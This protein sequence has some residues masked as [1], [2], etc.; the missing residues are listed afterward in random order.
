M[1]PIPIPYVPYESVDVDDDESLLDQEAITE[2]LDD[3]RPRAAS[4]DVHDA[5]KAR[6]LDM[7]AFNA[8]WQRTAAFLN[9]AR[10]AL[11]DMRAAQYVPSHSQP[12]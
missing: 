11:A 4:N 9:N 7:D 1:Q 5:S 10:I 12:P 6:S 2:M 8:F 3:L